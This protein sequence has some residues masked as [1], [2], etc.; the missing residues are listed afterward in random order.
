MSIKFIPEF[1][2]PTA[3]LWEATPAEAKELLLANIW[4]GKCRRGVTITNF[5]GVANGDYLLLVGLCSEC[6]GDVARL[7]ER[8]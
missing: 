1:T 3:K 7:V 4:C 6:Q 5:T 2:D 8:G